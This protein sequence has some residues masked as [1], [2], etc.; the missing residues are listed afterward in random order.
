MPI[1]ARAQG[2]VNGVGPT[3]LSLAEKPYYIMNTF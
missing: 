3:F 2:L 1:I